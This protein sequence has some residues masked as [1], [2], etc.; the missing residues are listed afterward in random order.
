MKMNITN[1]HFT[2]FVLESAIESFKKTWTSVL[3][4]KNINVIMMENSVDKSLSEPE[5]YAQL[6]ISGLKLTGSTD[7]Y[8][9]GGGAVLEAEYNYWNKYENK[10]GINWHIFNFFRYVKDG[11]QYCKLIS[12]VK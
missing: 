5:Q 8:C 7:V 3:S 4:D 1:V 11:I 10:R 9:L 12:H 6:G 2:A